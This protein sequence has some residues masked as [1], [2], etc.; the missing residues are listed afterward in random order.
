MF[1]L[2]LKKLSRP[3]SIKKP[4]ADYREREREQ[5]QAE[6]E[7]RLMSA[8]YTIRVKEKPL[9]VNYLDGRMIGQRHVTPQFCNPIWQ[10]LISNQSDINRANTRSKL[11]LSESTSDAG[12]GP[13]STD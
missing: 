4:V 10:E 7:A 6:R 8:N 2:L 1:A 3:D 9:S 12:V 5:R 13:C 11:S